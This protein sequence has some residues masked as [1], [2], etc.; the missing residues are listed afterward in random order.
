MVVRGTFRQTDRKKERLIH[1]LK[2]ESNFQEQAMKHT[3]TGTE[4]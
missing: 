3:R 2:A 1:I 4:C